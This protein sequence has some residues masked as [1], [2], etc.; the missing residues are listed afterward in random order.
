MLYQKP[1]MNPY[2]N[3]KSMNKMTI[4]FLVLFLAM[5][6]YGLVIKAENKI[7]TTNV[8]NQATAKPDSL[9]QDVALEIQATYESMQ[10]EISTLK[11]DISSLKSICFIGAC[12]VIILLLLVVLVFIRLANKASKKRL[13]ASCENLHRRIDKMKDDIQWKNVQSHHATARRD[14]QDRPRKSHD[15]APYKPKANASDKEKQPIAP[16]SENKHSESSNEHKPE[17]KQIIKELYLSNNDGDIFTKSFEKKQDGCN[18]LIEY[19]PEDKTAMGDLNVIGGLNA[20]R[21]MNTNSRDLSI[22]VVKS[23]CTWTEATDYAQVHVGKV[24]MFKG[25]WMIV[26]P[27]EIELKR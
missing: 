17:R 6:S 26:N 15:D 4:A 13:D 9:E 27:V 25:G 3:K 7:D 11:S 8:E 19:D 16:G 10:Q 22:K 1:F 20:L 23:N 24:R 2:F 12:V 14:E 5:F 18:F 21:V